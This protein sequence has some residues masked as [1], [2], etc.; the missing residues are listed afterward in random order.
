MTTPIEDNE[1]NAELQELY[2][3]GKQW[4]SD[5]DFFEVEIKSVARLSVTIPGVIGL[6]GNPINLSQSYV[7]LKDEIIK[8]MNAL[9]ILINASEKQITVN[10]LED[11]IRLRE[12]AEALMTTYRAERKLVFDHYHAAGAEK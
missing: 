4:L 10:L 2:L 9:G 12:K 8:F 3:T 6:T 5:L 7:L 11:H 1:L